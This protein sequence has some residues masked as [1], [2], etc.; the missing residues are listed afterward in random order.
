MVG[1]QPVPRPVC[2]LVC[3]RR[4]CCGGHAHAPGCTPRP[5]RRPGYRLHRVSRPGAAGGR[6]PGHLSA[7]DIDAVGAEI[8][9]GSWLLVLRRFVCLHHLRGRHG[10]LLGALARSR[11]SQFRGWSHAQRC[12]AANRP[13]CD[14]RWLG[15]SICCPGQGQDAGRTAH[16]PGLVSALSTDQGAWRGRSGLHRWLRPDLP[17]HCRPG[18]TACLRCSAG[19]GLAGYPRLQPRCWRSG[20]RD[21]RNRIYGARQGLSARCR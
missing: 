1:T 17:G 3:H 13:G 21:G 4:W 6:G 5:L 10:H 12:H 11:V 16:A 20:R 18:E 9:S 8:Q 19:Q 15:L 2:H 7:D 14:W